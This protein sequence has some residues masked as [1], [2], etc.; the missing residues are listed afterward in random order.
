LGR[1]LIM[2]DMTANMCN[3]GKGRLGHAR[4][5]TLWCFGHNLA[6]CKAK[7][8]A[9]INKVIRAKKG[10]TGENNDESHDTEGFKK[11]TYG[12]KKMTIDS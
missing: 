1:P 2:D 7:R 10:N 11:V 3:N 9:E 5:P 8:G 12:K 4:M 6:A